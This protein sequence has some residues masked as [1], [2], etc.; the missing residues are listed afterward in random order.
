MPIRGTDARFAFSYRPM[1]QRSSIAGD[2]AV[3][4]TVIGHSTVDG[5]NEWDST[6]KKFVLPLDVT[7]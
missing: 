1:L 6:P 5:Q 3:K 2:L 4:T 7:K